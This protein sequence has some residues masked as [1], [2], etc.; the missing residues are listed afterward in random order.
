[1][2][3]ALN[4]HICTCSCTKTPNFQQLYLDAGAV[5]EVRIELRL[6]HVASVFLDQLLNPVLSPHMRW[7]VGVC[8]QP[9]PPAGSEIAF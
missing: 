7:L 6:G 3:Y 5:E 4:S 2:I 8:F 1:M 9:F